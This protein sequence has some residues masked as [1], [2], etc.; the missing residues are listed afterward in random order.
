MRFSIDINC[1][2][3]EGMP[4]DALIMPYISSANIA[5]G[6]H[7]GNAAI[8]QRTIDL[9]IEHKVAI[10]AH[11]S[12]PDRE[13]FGRTNMQLPP[14][15]IYDIVKEQIVILANIAAKRNYQLTHVKPHGALY[16][17]AANDEVLAETI[18]DAILSVSPALTVMELC[19]SKFIDIARS[20]GLQAMKEV[21]ADRRYENDGT[22]TPR[23]Q[24]NALLEDE[25]SVEKQVLR[26][27]N[28][29]IADT[30]CIHGDGEHALKF[31]QLINHLVTS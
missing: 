4:N 23:T 21:F 18:C 29:G 10:G 17:M 8:M 27:L 3:G 24:P 30:I 16:N 19:G 28:E 7:A 22:L 12:F 9:A 15:K 25:G 1:D 14:Q 11:P 2:M 5:C 31:A 6:F 13:N 26:F 20:M